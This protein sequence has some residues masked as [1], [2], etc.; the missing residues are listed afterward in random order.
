MRGPREL[1]D[2]RHAL[3]AVAAADQLGGVA[4]DLLRE[5]LQVFELNLERGCRAVSRR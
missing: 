5:P 4:R 2:R 1:I 3:E